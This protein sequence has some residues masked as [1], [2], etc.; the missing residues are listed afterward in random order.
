LTHEVLFTDHLIFP[1]GT[2]AQ[3]TSRGSW[4]LVPTSKDKSV[5]KGKGVP[6]GAQLGPE[7]F[8]FSNYGTARFK[9]GHR[10][11][12]RATTL[13]QTKEIGKVEPDFKPLH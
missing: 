2:P 4:G 6:L 5:L 7:T 1:H 10:W 3:T 12:K 9:V 11:L 8:S 13:S